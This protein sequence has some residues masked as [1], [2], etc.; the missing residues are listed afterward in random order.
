MPLATY[1]SMQEIN[2]LLIG[3]TSG[4]KDTGS[5]TEEIPYQIFIKPDFRENLLPSWK[6]LQAEIESLIKEK[7]STDYRAKREESGTEGIFYAGASWK[8]AP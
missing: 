6:S 5:G 4:L 3:G 7:N 8:G 2:D 1:R